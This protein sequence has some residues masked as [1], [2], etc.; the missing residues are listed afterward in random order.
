M[1]TT[2]AKRRNIFADDKN[3]FYK[4][5]TV[6]ALFLKA[7]IELEK[8]PEWF[9]ANKLFLNADKPR[10][11][12]FHKLQD[13]DNLP[14]QLLALE[15]NNYK[16]KKSISIKFFG[17]MVDEHLNWNVHINIIENKFSKN[18]GLLHKAKQ[19]LNAKAIKSVYFSF[20]HSYLTY[21]NAVWCS[22]F[23]NKTKKLFNKQKQAIKIIPMADIDGNLNSD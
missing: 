13:G 17:V 6:K 18:L 22:T 14:L 15:I 9:Q 5:K 16:I 4:S 3:L 20:I 11:T 2:Y 1:L 8:I 19:F 10:F 21:G 12:L 23:M 7:N